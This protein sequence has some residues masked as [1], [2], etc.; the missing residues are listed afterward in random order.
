[1]SAR[2]SLRPKT[3]FQVFERD[4]F[5]CQ[6]CGKKP[7]EHDVTLEIDHTVSVKDGGTNAIENLVTSCWEC[8]RGKGVKSLLKRTKT[9]DDLEQ[10]LDL[11]KERLKQVKKLNLVRSNI[12]NT[13]KQIETATNSWL[14]DLLPESVPESVSK[15]LLQGQK[16]YKF[17][18]E[19]LSEAVLIA[20]DKLWPEDKGFVAYTMGVA[21]N[22]DLTDEE[23]E[24]LRLYKKEVF[25]YDRMD[26]KIRQ[27]ILDFSEYGI[28]FHLDVISDVRYSFQNKHG[29]T[30]LLREVASEYMRKDRYTVYKSGANLALL[31]ADKIAMVQE[32]IY[33]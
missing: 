27:M 25:K 30:F 16:K 24:I 14:T 4:N 22:L 12:E 19:T 6:Y 15:K 9:V 3:R 21:K 33:E 7:D 23:Q 29:E 2:I 13:K 8:N 10:E 18:N 32:R 28:E 17:S 20:V 5:T 1:M 11:A 26:Q 31:V